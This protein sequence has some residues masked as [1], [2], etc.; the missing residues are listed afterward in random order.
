[1][2][3]T[4]ILAVIV[5]LFI[6]G[7]GMGYIVGFSGIK[8]GTASTS[9]YTSTVVSNATVTKS[10]TSEAT[11]TVQNNS[12]PYDLTLAI[13]TQNT[14]NS[15]VGQ[16]PAYYV[17]TPS[18]L[19]SSANISLPAHRLIKL[20]IICYD[21]GPAPLVFNNDVNVSG[22]QGNLESIVNN[23]NVNSSQG[24]TSINITGG[25][26]VSNVN[27]SDIAHTFTIPQLGVNLPIP[28][29]S[30]VTAYLT[31]NDTGTFQWF[32]QTECGFGTTGQL[33]AMDTPGWMTG[34]I[35][36]S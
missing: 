21:D 22:T 5:I 30:T 23:D 13:T 10:L 32:C 12:A 9:T 35:T 20:V 31:L 6:A 19:V 25:Q 3:N 28:P 17:V 26:V 33:G 27:M 7:I 4:A 8:T 29:S 1:M 18:G 36:V 34:D 2:Q 15:T 14:F 11:T 16:Q 24:S